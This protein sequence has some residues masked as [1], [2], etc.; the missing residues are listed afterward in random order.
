MVYLIVNNRV[1]SIEISV[2]SVVWATDVDRLCKP[3]NFEYRMITNRVC[4]VIA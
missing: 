2:L 4:F 3:W 1:A